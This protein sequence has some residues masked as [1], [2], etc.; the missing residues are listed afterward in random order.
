M[1][2]ST[3][4]AM[5]SVLGPV[6]D[7]S[8]KGALRSSAPMAITP[9]TQ[10]VSVAQTVAHPEM[11]PIFLNKINRLPPPHFLKIRV[12]LVRFRPWAPSKLLKNKRFSGS[13]A[14]V[15][16]NFQMLHDATRAQ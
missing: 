10:P 2:S 1:T 6:Y 9:A 5:A 14:S 13:S 8:G 16:T 15:S 11:G 12:S 7:P 3:L 4:R